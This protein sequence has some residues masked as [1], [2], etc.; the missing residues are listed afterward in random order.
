MRNDRPVFGVMSRGAR[1]RPL[2]ADARR[3]RGRVLEAAE[4]VFASQ[5]L[6]VPIDEIAR[7]AGVGAGTVYRHFPTK[8]SL[9]EAVAVRR[10]ELL[11]DEARSLA[12][13][14]DAGAAFFGF[15]DRMVEEM[16]AKRDLGDVLA[17]AGVDLAAATRPVRDRYREAMGRLLTRAQ[18]AGAVRRDVGTADL[19]ALLTGASLATRAQDADPAVLARVMGVIQAGLRPVAEG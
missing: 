17:D 14:S 7:H 3:N 10:V 11:A 1:I 19:V 12:D 2:R 5:G 6:S 18:D 15:L 16:A 4:A 8:E 13:A 9:F